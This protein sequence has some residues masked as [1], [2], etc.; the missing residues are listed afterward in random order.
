VIIVLGGEYGVGHR[1][2]KVGHGDTT[3]ESLGNL[4]EDT[5]GLVAITEMMMEVIWENYFHGSSLGD[6]DS[7]NFLLHSS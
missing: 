1:W 5:F 2:L 7:T 6:F 3:A 4:G